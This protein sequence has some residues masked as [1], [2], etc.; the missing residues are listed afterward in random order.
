MSINTSAAVLAAAETTGKVS[1]I[2]P[3][4]LPIMVYQAKPRQ[5]ATGPDFR[6]SWFAL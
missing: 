2:R 3:Y 5:L 4:T 1:S 6:A